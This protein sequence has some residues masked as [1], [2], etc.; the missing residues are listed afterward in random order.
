MGCPVYKIVNNFNGAALMKQPELAEQIVRS[1]KSVTTLSVS[2]KI[3]A[4]WDNPQECFDFAKR[5]ESAGA[6]M[7]TIHG[8][9]KAQGYSG[10]SDWNLIGE[11][12]KHLSIPVLANGDIHTAP[13]AVE[14]LKVTGCD[15]LSIARGALGNPWIFKQINELLA[16]QTPE[17]ITL[18]ERIRVIKQH[19]DFHVEESGEMGII[20][21]RKHLSWYFRGIDGAKPYKLRL[22]STFSVQEI[23]SILDEMAK[24]GLEH[25]GLS[26]RDANHPQAS[27]RTLMSK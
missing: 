14:A 5:L 20:T 9:T 10:T 16:G 18:T 24:A 23:H 7:I 26:S 4:G 12:K 1:M 19:L 22:H 13:L 21:F 6:D 2:V 27:T 8:R 11:L 3:R 17:P 25:D 15:G